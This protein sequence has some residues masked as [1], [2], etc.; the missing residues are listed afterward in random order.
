MRCSKCGADNPSSK[1][2]CGD[3]GAPLANF[4]PKCRADNPVGKTVLRRVW[5]GSGRIGD[6][7][8]DKQIGRFT[9]SG[10]RRA[11]G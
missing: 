8:L 9:H 11:R 5:D 7:C 4:C 6:G 10:G 3:C 2:F 1:K